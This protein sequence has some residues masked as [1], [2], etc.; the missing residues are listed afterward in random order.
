MARGERNVHL[1]FSARAPSFLGEP[2]MCGDIVGVSSRG[3]VNVVMGTAGLVQRGPAPE[4]RS[5]NMRSGL[6]FLHVFTW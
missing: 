6:V 5:M 3:R 1:C 4:A 2:V